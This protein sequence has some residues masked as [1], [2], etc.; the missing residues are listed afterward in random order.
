MTTRRT[1][2]PVHAYPFHP[3]TAVVGSGARAAFPLDSEDVWVVQAG[4]VDVFVVGL[5]NGAP[6]GRRTH[7]FRANVNDP[8]IG[9][10]EDSAAS[11]EAGW[12]LMAVPTNGARLARA[13][14]VDLQ[15]IT[16]TLAGAQAV[17]DMVDRWVDLVSEGIARDL[18]PQVSQTLDD[19]STLEVAEDSTV[20]PH[21][22]VRWIRHGNGRSLFLGHAST[23][24]NGAG[25]VPLSRHAWLEVPAGAKLTIVPT[26]NVV[27]EGTVWRG[28]A[29]LH[30]L[31]IGAAGVVAEHA[32]EADRERLHRKTAGNRM[33]VS[34]ACDQLVSA[35]RPATGLR[36]PAASRDGRIEDPLLVV[37]RIVATALGIEVRPH[38]ARDGSPEPRNPLAAIAR[39]SRFR[40]RRV[41]LRDDWWRHDN[42]P[43]LAYRTEG[44]TPV[45]LLCPRAGQYELHEPGAVPVPV[46]PAV[47]ETLQ[48]FG[49]TFYRPFAA[50]AL[51]IRDVLAFGARG[52]RRDITT[53]VLVS[54]AAATLG[55][56]P[57]WT[58]GRLF[59]DVV[60][61]AER[62]QLLQLTIVLL[63]TAFAAA[64]FELARGIALLRVEGTMGNAIQSAVWDR[65]LSLPMSFFRPYT[66]GELANRAMGIDG[67]RQVIAGTTVTAII[68]GIMGL[69]NFIL[70]F[71]YSRKLA[72]W[73]TGL[74]LFALLVTAC[75]SWLQLRHQREVSALQSRVSGLVLQLLSSISKLR[76]TGSEAKAFAAWATPFSRQ[77]ALQFRVRSVGIWVAAFNA[78]FPL[79]CYGTI[80]AIADPLINESREIRTGDFLAFVAAFASCL[81]NVLLTSTALLMSLNVIPLYE[82][83]RPI[84]TALPEVDDAKTDPGILTGSLELQ[85][86]HF[87][88]GPDS[89]PVLRGL[90]LH[91]KPG[92][93]VAL[94][95]AS[96]SGKSTALRMLLGFEAPESGSV[97]FDGQDLAGLDVQ[98][99]RRQIGVV[100]QSGRL[101]S[102]DIFTNIV[103]SAN[104][105]IAD[106]W[107]AARMAG[108]DDD[109][110]SMPMGMH[111]V[112]SEGGGTL[113]G[114]QRQRLLI[115]RAIVH[116]PRILF[117]DE[118]TSALDNRTQAIVTQSLDRLQATR[119]VVAHRLSTI[120]HADRI[121]VV[122]RGAIAE[123][124]TYEELLAQEGLFAQ[125]ARRQIA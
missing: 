66:A 38:P 90:T 82:L 91:V 45:A 97:Y 55:L 72:W 117:F 102:G 1:P 86:V 6:S 116:R 35:L 17:A 111:T 40:T 67:I 70:M 106:A 121:C 109:I 85:N 68:G 59:N 61:G 84:L 24:V 8:L 125:L 46:T 89:A 56:L 14:Q 112:V 69:S 88:Y 58:T 15:A 36:V 42:G 122:D 21:D 93:Y 50:T 96:G 64:M 65:L 32:D 28:L 23:T 26:A 124:G 104:A 22:A 10:S 44:E 62:G 31:V 103:G 34:Y 33:A 60:P 78:A 73:A 13:S 100:L 79:I 52:C 107:E 120:Q 12:R 101:M 83:A 74:I 75:G 63:V 57:S 41:A 115:A 110:K 7:L 16:G 81:T 25:D 118:A 108:F 39:A 54:L 27:A 95:G 80:F 99:V 49:Y 94:V 53:I 123:S 20:R 2:F 47:A 3:V 19:V 98:S 71:W 43:L 30:S 48:P 9:T 29:R 105:T 51:G 37:T 114:G 11:R 4:E 119:I 92:E 18:A 5:R 113:S 76:V 77:R 87:R